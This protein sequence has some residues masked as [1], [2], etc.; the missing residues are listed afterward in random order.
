MS[1]IAETYLGKVSL[2]SELQTH[3]LFGSLVHEGKQEHLHCA[4]LDFSEAE[5]L[6]AE[7]NRAECWR[8]GH[9]VVLLPGVVPNY[10]RRMRS[11]G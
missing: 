2:A 11:T 5:L 7:Q 6:A 4:T 10:L 9:W 3:I 1:A 8:A